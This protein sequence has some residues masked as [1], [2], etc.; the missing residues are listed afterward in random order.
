MYHYAL[1]NRVERLLRNE[2]QPEDLIRLFL[3]VRDKPDGRE[4]VQEIGD[5]VAHHDDRN[6]GITTLAVRDFFTVL[7][8]KIPYLKKSFELTDL[9]PTFPNVLEAVARRVEGR[10]IKR[11]TGLTRAKAHKMLPDLV[12]KLKDKPNGN[13]TFHGHLSNKELRLIKCLSS[14]IVSKPAFD[15][16]RL[17]TEF[18]ETLKSHGLITKEEIRTHSELKPIIGLYAI[19]AMH[20]SIVKL[21]DG[22][23]A[24]LYASA[25]ADKTDEG[26][27]VMA[28]APVSHEGNTVFVGGTI[29][30]TD[31]NPEAFCEPRLLIETEP[32]KFDIEL[33][34]QA[35]LDIVR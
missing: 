21:N 7:R 3:F 18:I 10:I 1:R 23:D 6:K 5:F 27:S 24:Q 19:T 17:Y 32:W 15:H 31:L 8:V 34:P 35:T 9:P 13:L 26:I 12:A 30:S 25:S 22:D 14:Y 20:N 33:R 16:D 4:T 2:Y 28:T 11:D 29:F